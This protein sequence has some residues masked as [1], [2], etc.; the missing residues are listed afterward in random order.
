MGTSNQLYIALASFIA[1]S[2]QL[3]LLTSSSLDRHCNYQCTDPLYSET[4]GLTGAYIYFEL[5]PNRR[6]GHL[7]TSTWVS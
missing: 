4:V 3:V 1:P 7:N 6:C 2:V 5:C